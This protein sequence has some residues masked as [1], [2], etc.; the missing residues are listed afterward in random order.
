MCCAALKLTMKINFLYITSARKSFWNVFSRH[1]VYN[2]P[3]ANNLNKYQ[4]IIGLDCSDPANCRKNTP[5]DHI[6]FAFTEFTKQKSV[7]QCSS[8]C[9]TAH[10]ISLHANN[11]ILEFQLIFPV[12]LSEITRLVK[13]REF[14]VNPWKKL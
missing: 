1:S 14:F 4:P 2:K 7:K 9:L 5:P 3:I 10:P 12:I 6:V 11:S 13:P 8:V